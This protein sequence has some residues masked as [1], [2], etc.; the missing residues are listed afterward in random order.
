M[1]QAACAPLDLVLDCPI[2]SKHLT[3]CVGNGAFEYAFGPK[4]APELALT[5][6]L[7][8]VAASPWPGVGRSIWEDIAFANNDVTYRVWIAFDRLVENGASDGGV[9]VEQ[10]GR[11]IAELQCQEDKAEIGIFAIADAMAAAG[12]CVDPEQ[13]VYTRSCEK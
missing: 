2:G 5:V 1:G 13:R 10:A 6:P 9:Q 8:E 7:D 4:D 12:F 11:V 3:A